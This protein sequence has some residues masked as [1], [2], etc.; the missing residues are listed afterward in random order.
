MVVYSE[1][2]YLF[3]FTLACTRAINL[4]N[5]WKTVHKA[6]PRPVYLFSENTLYMRTND[7][8]GRYFC[9]CSIHHHRQPTSQSTL[10]S[11]QP[12]CIWCHWISV[13]HKYYFNFITVKKYEYHLLTTC[14]S[15]GLECWKF[16]QAAT[17]ANLLKII[18]KWILNESIG[19][20]GL[21]ADEVCETMMSA[22]RFE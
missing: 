21:Y 11:I 14:L 5:V 16:E 7:C 1:F 15:V 4:P 12:Q 2:R 10:Q 19:G 20:H 3:D 17:A 18:T 22:G 9:C 8:E 6:I 13:I